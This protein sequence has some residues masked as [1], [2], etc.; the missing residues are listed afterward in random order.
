MPRPIL[1]TGA[2][3]NVG[4]EVRVSLRARGAAVRLATRDGR[5]DDLSDDE[6]AVRLDLRDPATFGA[7]VEG[8]GALFLLRPPAIADTRATLVPLVDAARAAGVGQVVFLSVA[9]AGRNPL[10]PHHAVERH[11]QDGPGA[12]TILR[13]GFFAQNIGTAYRADVVQDDRLYVPAGRG[14]VA[15][16]DLRDVGEVAAR[17]LLAPEDFAGQALTL[18]GPEAVTFDDVAALLSAATGRAVRY[19]AAS[20]AGYVRHLRRGGMGWPQALVQTVLH[21]GLRFGQAARVDPTLGAV[22][23]HRPRGVADYVRDHA[24]LWTGGA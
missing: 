11:L 23:G 1:L 5:A 10:V 6:N 4:R 7:A 20:V 24:A 15:F 18:T 3:G 13:P 22:L 19:D 17:A 12:W 8:C 9:G 21:V 14:R 2:S 16:V